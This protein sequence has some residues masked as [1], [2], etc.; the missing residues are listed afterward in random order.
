MNDSH[1]A[2][3]AHSVRS[4]YSA[5]QQA[6]EARAA[7]AKRRS[8]SAV[9]ICASSAALFG[10]MF[11]LRDSL[12]SVSILGSPILLLTALWQIRAFAHH[13]RRAASDAHRACFY[14]RGIH[15]IDGK[16][17]G[18][19]NAG[20]EY[21]VESHPYQK[22]LDILGNGSL[23]ELLA[24][25]RSEVGAERLAAYLLNSATA[26]EARRRQEAV[27]EL[28]P[29]VA[30]REEIAVLGKYRFH[31]CSPERVREWLDHPVLQVPIAIRVLLG[32]LSFL[33]L[34]LV[35]AGV[36]QLYPWASLA[37]VLAVPLSIQAVIAIG[38]MRQVR[39]RIEVLRTLASDISILRGG[40][41]LI[42]PLKF[43]SAKLADIAAG[44]S[45]Q[46]AGNA[47]RALE[48]LLILL[49]RREDPMLYGIS[50]WF[51]AGTQLVLA[52]EKWRQAHQ[53][54]LEHWLLAWGEFEALCALAGYAHEHPDDIFPELI[55]GE[56]RF[57]AR[58]M[59]HPLLPDDIS[60]RNDILLNRATRFYI[61]SGS[62]MAGKSTLLRAIG[63]NTVLANAG[64]PVRATHAC[65]AVMSI[66]A[67]IATGD[68]LRDGASKFFAEVE[69]LR[70]AI[71]KAAGPESVLF[72][73]DEM[74]AGT[75]SRDRCIAAGAMV[76]TLIANGAAGALSTHDV[77]LTEIARREELC[78]ANV[79][80]QS[81]DPDNPLDFDYRLRPGIASQTNGLAIVRLMG[82]EC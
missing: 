38:L 62:N 12:G 79:H 36:V 82:L 68:S 42:A 56:A 53:V 30:M 2:S 28:E 18:E 35:L 13:R 64:A 78:G 61:V 54:E 22:D 7:S 8:L 29:E 72:L 37:P 70:Y 43:R 3:S 5:R 66:C 71:V 10:V 16:W 41:E 11:L 46:K 40:I 57:E 63:Q 24:T 55:E 32:M 9:V 59:G 49:G 6:L 81:K 51:A 50:I 76:K 4:E 73:V 80:M 60:V 33:S 67:S 14:E 21:A 20:A 52:I 45:A 23:F 25:T 31:D 26:A 77:A 44:F 15:R 75:N 69:R 1:P 65:I 27:K 34:G 17:H 39:A 48:R 74:L 58:D 47:V 19:G